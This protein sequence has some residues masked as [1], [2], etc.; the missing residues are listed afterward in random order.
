MKV[1]CIAVVLNYIDTFFRTQ[2]NLINSNS[3]SVKLSS[4]KDVFLTSFNVM[5]FTSE[6][7]L[8]LVSRKILLI[9]NYEF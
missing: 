1:K 3:K 5:N 6:S 2:Q 7:H 9:I 8:V 4:W